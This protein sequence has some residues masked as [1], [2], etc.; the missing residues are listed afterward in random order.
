MGV[1]LAQ[2]LLI[3]FVVLILFGAGKL[4]TVMGDLGRGLRAFRDEL[5]SDK[6]SEKKKNNRK[7]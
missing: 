1:S 2:L 3:L 7:K 6:N 5:K 4:P